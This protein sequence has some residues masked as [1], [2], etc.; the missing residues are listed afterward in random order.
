MGDLLG[1]SVRLRRHFDDEAQVLEATSTLKD[2]RC[3]GASIERLDETR[4]T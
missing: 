3:G 4:L 1:V 2:S